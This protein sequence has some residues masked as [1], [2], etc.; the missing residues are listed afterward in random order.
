MAGGREYPTVVIQAHAKV[1]LALQVLGKRADGY[2]EVRMVMTPLA[3]HDRLEVEV[4]GGHLAVTADDPAVPSGP[5]NLVYRAAAA[6]RE[7]A[8]CRYGARIRLQK[9]IPTTAGLGG[10][11]ADA[12]AALLL[13]N[14]LWGLHWPLQRLQELATPLGADIPFCLLGRTALAEG[15]G[16]RLTP[17]PLAPRVPVVVATPEVS[18]PGPKTA[19]VYRAY[20]PRPEGSVV[21]VARVEAALQEG[22]GRAL[23]AAL[24][25]DLE[26]GATRL[27]PVIGELKARMLAAGAWG[28]VMAGAGPS[29]LALCPDG[30][31]AE[32]V[33]AAARGLATRV[34]VSELVGEVAAPIPR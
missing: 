19:T 21:D 29:V 30:L 33:A 26:P 1:N 27:Q 5:R 31:V 32:R 11:S 10:G 2:H 7:Q 22:D 16:E 14:H 20:Q 13:L 6:L 18:W 9:R 3:L 28:A 15:I 17:L 34:V 24:G 25:N 23:A 4:T 8:G 12:A